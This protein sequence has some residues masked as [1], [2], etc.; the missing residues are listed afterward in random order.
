MNCYVEDQKLIRWLAAQ[1]WLGGL[2]GLQYTDDEAEN[3]DG[4][5]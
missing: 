2:E 5:S 4:S 3:V 1:D